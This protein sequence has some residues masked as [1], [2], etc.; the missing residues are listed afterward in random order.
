MLCLYFSRESRGAW[1]IW[2]I[3]M[4]SAFAFLFFDVLFE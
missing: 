3:A 4:N 1:D 2:N